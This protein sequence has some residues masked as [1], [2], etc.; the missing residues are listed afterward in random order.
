MGGHK[1]SFTGKIVPHW[2]KISGTTFEGPIKGAGS[3]PN[4]QIR[5]RFEGAELSGELF[6]EAPF[7]ELGTLWNVIE[8]QA[9]SML[10]AMAFLQAVKVDMYI[11]SVK[12]ESCKI[13][14]EFNSVDVEL[15][16]VL[17]ECGA[18]EERLQKLMGDHRYEFHMGNALSHAR[19]ALTN[20]GDTVLHGYRAIETLRNYFIEV[21]GL[22]RDKEGR[23][24]KDTWQ[25]FREHYGVEDS[26]IKRL[27]ELSKPLRHGDY[28]AAVVLDGNT[29]GSILRD[30]WYVIGSFIR[31]EA[32]K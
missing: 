8:S 12:N 13:Q 14:I 15:A 3:F 22:E 30:I 29:R 10:D 18:T 11:D 32:S 25:R 26:K 4:C 17:T 7:T 27:A 5:V 21:M 6:A 19:Q 20:P 16:K 2:V 1:Y 23:P 24:P 31:V 9:K 28:R